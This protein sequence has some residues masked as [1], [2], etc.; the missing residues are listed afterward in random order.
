MSH[1]TTAIPV[2]NKVAGI[3]KRTVDKLYA[4]SNTPQPQ[5]VD[6]CNDNIHMIKYGTRITHSEVR[7]NRMYN[8]IVTRNVECTADVIVEDV[9][10]SEHITIQYTY[11]KQSN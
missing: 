11:V 2:I 8:S 10:I 1:T 4:Q 5:S 6:V 9:V 3:N 7:R